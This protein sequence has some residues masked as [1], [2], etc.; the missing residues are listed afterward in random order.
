MKQEIVAPHHR[1]FGV[2]EKKRVPKNLPSPA[3]D[4]GVPPI[5]LGHRV[6]IHLTQV[7]WFCG[8]IASQQ[9]P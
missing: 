9:F 5:L 7:N 2:D 3:S 4:V 6:A 8:V 1:I